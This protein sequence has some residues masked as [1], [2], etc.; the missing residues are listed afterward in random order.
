MIA[1]PS[2]VEPAPK[3]GATTSP[4]PAS[5][6]SVLSRVARDTLSREASRRAMT[7]S[8]TVPAIIAA[9]LESM[10]VSAMWTTPTPNV[11]RSAP[12]IAQ[13]ASSRGVTLRLCPRTARIAATSR[14]ATRNRLPAEMSGGS[15]STTILIP[16]YVDPQ[17]N[18][19]TSRAA[20]TWRT[21][22]VMRGSTSRG[23]W[24]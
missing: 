7:W 16:R 21:G 13:P 12:A 24:L 10:R 11:R 18:Q 22:A 4:R 9:T 15:V 8:G 17:T 1:S 19:T 23:A 5:P 3:P 6:A 20:Q 2:A 14:P